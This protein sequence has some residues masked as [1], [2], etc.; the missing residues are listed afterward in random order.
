MRDLSNQ[1]GD[2]VIMSRYFN[3]VSAALGRQKECLVPTGKKLRQWT[4][5][6]M[7]TMVLGIGRAS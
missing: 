3:T 5:Q 4:D 2:A 7:S 1:S 6:T